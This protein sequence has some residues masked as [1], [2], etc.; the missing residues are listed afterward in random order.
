MSSI[1]L[2]QEAA[3]QYGTPL[4]CFDNEALTKRIQFLRS[5]LPDHVQ[6][7][8]AAKANTFI[9]PML[10][11]MIDHYEICS[12]GEFQ[13]CKA[14]NIPN[15]KI[16]LSGVYKNPDDLEHLYYS[17]EDIPMLT[18]ESMEQFRNIHT[19]SKQTNKKA[20]ILL[21]LTSGN[22]FGLDWEE[23]KQ[24]V[25]KKDLYPLLEFA[26]I[27][28]FS[29]TQK[30][31]QKKI[32]REMNYLEEVLE[33]L[34]E[35]N[36]KPSILEYG[37]GFPVDYFNAMSYEEK[38]HF[39]FFSDQLLRFQDVTIVL[40]LGRSIAAHCGSYI[41]QIVDKKTNKGQNYIIVDGGIHHLVYYGQGMAMKLP[42]YTFLS[43]QSSMEKGPWNV[44]GALCT[45]NDI[46]MKQVILPEPELGDYFVFHNVG[47]Y[48]PTEG[49]SLFLTRDLPAICA[50]N[51][52]NMTLLRHHTSVVALNTPNLLEKGE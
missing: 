3:K 13:I 27:Q 21:R 11:S 25:Y 44:C 37:P 20:Q 26:G 28:F 39:A 32:L 33:K 35:L 4:Y 30:F 51:K 34:S 1:H 6:L 8:Y 50:L 18:I 49:M 47:A 5:S 46:L 38:E 9:L 40:E 2:I 7:C 36:Y 19:L 14:L 22:Q 42:P 48:C 45:V 17:S 16:V 12:P 41:T 23:V 15:R 29:G 10:E 52:E 43:S 24:L 31:S